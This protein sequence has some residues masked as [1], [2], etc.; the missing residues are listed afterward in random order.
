MNF[1]F[2]SVATSNG[3]DAYGHFLRS[4]LQLTSCV[5]LTD[6]FQDICNATF[7]S[8]T[9]TQSKKKKGKKSKA[10]A[11]AKKTKGSLRSASPLPPINVPNLQDLLPPATQTTPEGTQPPADTG[12][13]TTT[14]DSAPKQGS[15]ST[16]TT[17]QDV[18]L[19][20]ASMFLQFLLGGGA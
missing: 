8:T 2:N 16:T 12:T 4:N 7:K 5:E 14:P 9:P 13:T 20:R 18:S 15:D 19:R 17:T 3:F 1:I 11:A 6:V 10:K